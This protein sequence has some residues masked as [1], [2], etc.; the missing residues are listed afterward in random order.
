V[1][2]A[3]TRAAPYLEIEATR[4]DAG[5]RLDVVL[6]RRV[7]GLSR[8][9]AQEMLEEGSIRL[10]GRR[11]RKGDR[12]GEGDR[13]ALAH[14][15][16]PSDFPARPDATVPI[17]I[18]YEDSHL[19]VIDKPA[20]VPSHPLRPSETGTAASFVV[21]R[22]P[23]TCVVGYR[24]REP[25]IVHRLDTGTSGLLLVAKDT[26]TFDALRARLESD[27]I[28]KRYVAFVATSRNLAPRAIETPIA[29]DP[30]DP[31]KVAVGAHL[32]G[33]RPART[34]L[35]VVRERL[36]ATELELRAPHAFRHQ[37]RAHLAS[38][39]HPLLGDLLYG[40]EAIAGLARHA[41]HASVLRLVH[42]ATG[43]PLRV[44]SPLPMDLEALTS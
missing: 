2:G 17:T 40:G 33:A 41:L 4:E 44:E 6:S 28:D 19:A 36:R 31:R 37:V 18:L 24:A 42:P 27:G 13:I 21:A 10:D 25:G 9:R 20:G 23:E 14:A 22:W 8:R 7:P 30:R 5:S 11:A 15:P 16:V 29:N 38:E 26:A 43:R 39:G 3:A 35:L 32:P 34:Q 1:T 12:V